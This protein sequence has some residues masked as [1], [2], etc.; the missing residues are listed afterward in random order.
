MRKLDSF[1]VNIKRNSSEEAKQEEEMDDID[2]DMSLEDDE[3]RKQLMMYSKVD[4]INFY[5]N[6]I[7]RKIE[8]RKNQAEKLTDMI[9]ENQY[10]MNMNYQNLSVTE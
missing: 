10:E 8:E 6:S 1:K 5:K 7:L 3:F 4:V 9:A 2:V